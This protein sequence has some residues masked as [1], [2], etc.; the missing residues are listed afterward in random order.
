ME[1]LS[2]IIVKPGEAA[3]VFGCNSHIIHIHKQDDSFGR[4]SKKAGISQALL[5]A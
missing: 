1:S 5:E 3:I 2:E 4:M